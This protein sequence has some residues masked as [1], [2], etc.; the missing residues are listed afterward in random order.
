L[1]K[2]GVHGPVAHSAV[3]PCKT[4]RAGSSVDNSKKYWL[5]PLDDDR[6]VKL[7]CGKLLANDAVDR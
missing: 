4:R 2:A 5:S 6:L 1:P 3:G 7:I